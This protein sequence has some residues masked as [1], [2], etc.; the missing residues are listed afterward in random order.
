VCSLAVLDHA[1]VQPQTTPL[2]NCQV[3]LLNSDVVIPAREGDR[4]GGE[5]VITVV[6]LE[7]KPAK[8]QLYGSSPFL[9]T[10]YTREQTNRP[11]VLRADLQIYF[12]GKNLRRC[13]IFQGLGRGTP[14]SVARQ[15]HPRW[16][17]S[18]TL[19][20]HSQLGESLWSPFRFRIRLR[21]R[22][23]TSNFLLCT[24]RWW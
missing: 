17:I 5:I 21:T 18:V 1:A 4:L 22:S 9:I 3:W 24:N 15:T 12:Y 20:G 16:H 7:I 11:G 6:N 19:K 2:S 14:L 8:K 10:G 13:S 23:P